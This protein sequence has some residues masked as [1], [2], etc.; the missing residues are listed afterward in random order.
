[1]TKDRKRFE[2]AH[3]SSTWEANNIPDLFARSKSYVP[4]CFE[5]EVNINI[6]IKY[7]ARA[8]EVFEQ[9]LLILIEFLRKC[10]KMC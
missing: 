8:L 7:R 3:N 4:R 10:Y 9:L 1:M 5:R 6:F 2:I